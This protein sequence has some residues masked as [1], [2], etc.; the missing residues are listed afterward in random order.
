M[1]RTAEGS[2][3]SLLDDV[4]EFCQGQSLEREFKDFAETQLGMRDVCC[5]KMCECE[6]LCVR[7]LMQ[8]CEC[9]YVAY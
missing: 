4:Q 3:H 1:A 6:C 5:V 7:M 9:A 8:I 2:L